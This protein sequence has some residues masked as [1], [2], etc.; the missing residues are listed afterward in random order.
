LVTAIA[1]IKAMTQTA[2]IPEAIT[3]LTDAE[4]RFGLVRIEDQQFF[5][6]WCE[7]LPDTNSNNVCDT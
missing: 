2:V 6:E 1:S 7:G 3:S 4:T 5:P